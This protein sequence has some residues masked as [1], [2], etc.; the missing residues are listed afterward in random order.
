M[1]KLVRERKWNEAPANAVA[2]Y[3]QDQPGGVYFMS[4]FIEGKNIQTSK[5]MLKK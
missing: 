2:F 5:I 3:L 1:G 4:A